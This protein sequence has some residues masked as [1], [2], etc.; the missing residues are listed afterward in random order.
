MDNIRLLYA[1]SIVKIPNFPF[2]DQGMQHKMAMLC[3]LYLGPTTTIRQQDTT[4]RSY[5]SS[6]IYGHHIGFI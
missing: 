6:V 3:E 5:M 4:N 2:P 1:V